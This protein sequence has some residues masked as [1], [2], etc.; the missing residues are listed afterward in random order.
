MWPMPHFAARGMRQSSDTIRGPA[1]KH[2]SHDA[3]THDPS[4]SIARQAALFVGLGLLSYALGAGI[5]A[6]ATEVFGVPETFAVAISLAVLVIVN[7]W[8]NRMLIFRSGGQPPGGQ[9]A[10]FLA[11]SLAMRGF[12]YVTFLVLLRVAHLHYLAAY[13]TALVISNAGKFLIYRSV[14]FR[15]SHGRSVEPPA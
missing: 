5:A 10:R 4:H 2:V 14:V 1:Q 13:T 3:P 12:E 8:L 15:R 9:F 6:L 7:F 11:T